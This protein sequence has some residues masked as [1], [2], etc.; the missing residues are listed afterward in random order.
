MSVTIEDIAKQLD[1]SVSTVSKALNNYSDVA[2]AT[3]KRILATARELNYYPNT[4]ARNL[5]RKRTEK[6]GVVVNY[7]INVVNDFLSELIP[8]A[9]LAA[10][11]ADYNLIL[12]TS[13]ARNPE[14]I[15]RICRA[16]EADGL[17]LLWP[18][19]LEDTIKLMSEEKMPYIVLPRR[20]P[21]SNVSYIAADHMTSG[22]MLTQHLLELGHTRIGYTNYPEIYESNID[23]FTGYRKAL[24]DAGIPFDQHLVVD[25]RHF[26]HRP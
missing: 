21:Y 13:A 10:E 2:P 15:S 11:Q 25:C 3:K 8:G 12:Y 24:T 19:Q 6:I 20:V 4:A 1:L 23:R 5:R 18:A 9:A 7:P 22:Y 16:R 26:H 17:L 14:R